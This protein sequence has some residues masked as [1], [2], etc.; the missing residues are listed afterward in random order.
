MGKGAEKP[1]FVKFDCLRLPVRD[2]EGAP[3]FYRDALGH[4]LA[5][6][7]DTAAGLRM[8]GGDGEIVLQTE[9]VGEE[10]DLLVE[11]APCR[12][13]LRCGW[14][15]PAERP[16][17]DSDRPVRGGGG[18]DRERVGD[19]GHEQGA[20]DYGH[21][22]ADRGERARGLELA[23]LLQ[24]WL[25]VGDAAGEGGWVAGGEDESGT[26]HVIDRLGARVGVVLDQAVEEDA[27]RG[28]D[29]GG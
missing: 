9:R 27:G 28:D 10:T 7:S 19:A 13:A 29:A 23:E 2:L 5:W 6:R 22:R 25:A 14:R 20:T 15:T 3:A 18:H 16:V 11:S 1:L 8:A 21:R 12:G 24:E 4:E 26:G 17:R